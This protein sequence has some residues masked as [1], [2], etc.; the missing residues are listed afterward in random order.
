VPEPA[1]TT[2]I[3]TIALCALFGYRERRRFAGFG[4]R[5]AALPNEANWASLK[6]GSARLRPKA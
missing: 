6:P 3:G 2:L 1:T 4:K 5:T